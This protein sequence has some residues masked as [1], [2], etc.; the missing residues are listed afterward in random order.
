[1]AVIVVP[2]PSSTDLGL[3]V[4]KLLRVRA[5]NVAHRR[6][7]DGE[8]YIRLEGDLTG[9]EAV[10]VQTTSP[11]QDSHLMQLLLMADVAK[12]LG[13]ERVVAVVPYLAYARQDKRFLKGEA[14]SVQTVA[15]FLA[16][17]GVDE[18]ITVNVHD[19]E[20]L[21]KFGFPARSVSC[22]SLLAEHLKVKGF[23]GAFA[24]A[25]DEG[26]S[27][28]ALE[29][30]RVLGGEYGW[31]GKERDRYTGE[32]TTERKK[33]DVEGRDVVVFDDIISTGGTTANAV[34]ILKEQGARRIFAA[35]A[36]PLMVGDA[37]GR[38][39]RSGA[40]GIVGTDCVPG[41]FSVV[42]VAPLIAKVLAEKG[43]AEGG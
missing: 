6:F 35:C 7:P 21:R 2:G 16:T 24:L 27:K 19:E 1:M 28:L 25:P 40:E 17:A 39:L 11:P 8:S 13:A 36:H 22:M 12:D 38:I 14:I 31:L 18:L 33:L 23:E 26:A 9:E 41:R 3:K 34:K 4:A 5:V 15:K 29:A 20:A 37:E 10:I 43:V 42:S 32:V 30:S